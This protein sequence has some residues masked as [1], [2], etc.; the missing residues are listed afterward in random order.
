M[1]NYGKTYTINKKTSLYLTS[2]CVNHLVTLPVTQQAA[3]LVNTSTDANDIV[4]SHVIIN[5]DTPETNHSMLT[6]NS[7]NVLC[8]KPKSAYLYSYLVNRRKNAELKYK[9]E[10]KK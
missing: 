2:N 8:N 7:T 1:E 10:I 5:N 6:L 4:G 3:T 9:E